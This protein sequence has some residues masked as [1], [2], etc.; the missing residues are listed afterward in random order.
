MSKP[1]GWRVGTLGDIA[2]V[3]PESLSALADRAWRFRYIDLS[4]AKRGQIDWAGTSELTLAQAPSRARRLVAAQD[5]LFGTVRPVLQSHGLV[6]GYTDEPLVASTGFTVL[7]A[8]VGTDPNYLFHLIMSSAILAEARRFEV[9]SN[10]PAVNESDVRQFKILIPPLAEQRRIGEILDAADKAIRSTERLIAKVEQA[11]QGLLRDLLTY[12]VNEF[13][14]LRGLD[15]LQQTPLGLVP[16][17]WAVG[18]LGRVLTSIDA[19]RSPDLP[20]RPAQADEWGVLKV[21]AIRPDGLQE[22]ENKVVTRSSLIDVNI[23]VKPGNLL[24]S[25]A[26]TPALVG[27]ACYVRDTCS[28][29]ML[30]DKTLRLNIDSK[31]AV[32]EFVGYLLQTSSSRRQLE[33]SGTGS[34]GSMKNISQAEIRSLILP[35]PQVDEQ[36]R[37]LANLESTRVRLDVLRREL[38]KLRLLKAGLMDDLL[39][40]RVRVGALG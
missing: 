10:Y 30:S 32:P 4:S 7:R 29:L 27:L 5:V 20:D 35:L 6:S 28:R 11:K 34:S 21:S 3:N 23:E 12:G 39:T 24:I 2:H 25:R 22:T 8:Q 26:N 14:H 38:S 36:Y 9:G 31:L 1:A 15:Q 18:P 37:I 40:G 33:T 16:R 19:G 17:E 13:G